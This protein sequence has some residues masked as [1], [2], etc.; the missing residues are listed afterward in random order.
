MAKEK[1][2][3]N[4]TA[5]ERGIIRQIAERAIKLAR[6]HGGERRNIVDI[7]MDIE[8][9]HCNGCP[10]RLADLLAADDFNFAHDVLGIGQH[11]DRENGK[12]ASYFLPRF[13]A[14]SISRVGKVQTAA[15][16]RKA[17]AEG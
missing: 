15:E 9:T 17:K 16:I 7:Q 11:L 8:A 2:K 10:L 6:L 5:A 3:W 4:A 14:P 12:L 13:S 1:I